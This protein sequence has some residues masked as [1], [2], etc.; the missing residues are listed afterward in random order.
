MMS[1]NWDHFLGRLG[2]Y[3]EGTHRIL[4]PCPNERIQAVQNQFGPMPNDLLDML[5][6][7]NG[8]KLFI[9]TGP[10]V[11]VFGITTVPSLS[12]LVWAPEWHIDRFTA[13]WRSSG[14][15]HDEW[16][17]AMMN[18]GVLIVLGSQGMTKEWDT[19]QR[20]WG[21]KELGLNERI[22]ELLREG[23]LYLSES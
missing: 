14:H 13:R 22:T 6:H 20:S 16:P 11:S 12:P 18:Y 19:G 23:E 17:I 15:S 9:K 1:T 4:P 7:F 10:L 2:E 5:R 3:P 8:A 21:G